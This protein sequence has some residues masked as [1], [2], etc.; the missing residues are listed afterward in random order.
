MVILTI[1]SI[2]LQDLACWLGCLILHQSF[3]TPTLQL[4]YHKQQDHSLSMCEI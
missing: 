4:P 3:E 1:E 2:A